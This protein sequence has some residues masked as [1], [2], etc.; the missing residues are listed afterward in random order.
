MPAQA[1]HSRQ[2][3]LSELYWSCYVQKLPFDVIV[4]G[5]NRTRCVSMCS[6]RLERAAMVHASSA[7]LEAHSTAADHDS[8]ACEVA[9]RN[10]PANTASCACSRAAT[11]SVRSASAA[12]HVSLPSWS[13]ASWRPCSATTRDRSAS[14]V[15]RATA[16]SA[17]A[18]FSAPSSAAACCAKVTPPAVAPR[19]S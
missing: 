4:I 9:P 15:E 14:A 11:C 6:A 5:D 12:V 19:N 10:P 1:Q 16:A 8:S 3:D 18:A 7:S 2:V 13:A 17:R